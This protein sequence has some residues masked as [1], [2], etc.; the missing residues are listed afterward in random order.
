VSFRRDR[1]LLT[2]SRVE[3]NLP[4]YSD[5][6][7]TL[8]NAQA[9]WVY[10]EELDLDTSLVVARRPSHRLSAFDTSHEPYIR[11]CRCSVR[12]GSG[13]AAL[14]E[15]RRANADVRIGIVPAAGGETKWMNLGDTRDY[16]LGAWC[17]RLPATRCCRALNRVQNKLD[18]MMA[19]S[20]R[21]VAGLVH[22]KIPVD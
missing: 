15:S 7:D 14:S 16:L 9:D 11:R 3:D 13:A 4:P 2:G 12:A 6:S 21:R 20:G 10:P 18:L 22:R 5:G 1:S 19:E 17:G 8:L